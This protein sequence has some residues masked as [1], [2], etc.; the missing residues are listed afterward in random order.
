MAEALAA[1]GVAASVLQIVDFGSR[2]VKTACELA[3]ASSDGLREDIELAKLVTEHDTVVARLQT[4]VQSR[5]VISANEQA[6]VDL[7]ARCRTQT[8]GLL[9]LLDQLKVSTS[10]HGVKR[11]I[12]SAKAAVRIQRKK[13]EIERHRGDLQLANGQL[14]TAL[15]MVLR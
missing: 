6:V 10:S 7:S 14:A 9:S 3:S 5:P 13:G 11:A 4:S 15:L 12:R 8:T 2:V 1:V